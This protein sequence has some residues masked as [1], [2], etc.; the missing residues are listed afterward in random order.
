MRSQHQYVPPS[1]AA[2]IRI[3]VLLACV[4]AASW[5]GTR[6]VPADAAGTGSVTA[7]TYIC[8]DAISLIA[9]QHSPFP[10]ALLAAC[11]PPALGFSYPQLRTAPG[12][13]PSTGRPFAPGIIVCRGP[14]LSKYG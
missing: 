6:P 7:R 3:A 13:K 1:A 5:V 9:V 2:S 11:H 10:D 12:G 4:I 14:A 8:P